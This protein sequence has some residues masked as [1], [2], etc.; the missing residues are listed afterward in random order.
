MRFFVTNGGNAGARTRDLRLK[1]ALLYQL[2]YIPKVGIGK[3]WTITDILSS[4][5]R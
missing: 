1:R 2:S 3:D 4:S 5:R